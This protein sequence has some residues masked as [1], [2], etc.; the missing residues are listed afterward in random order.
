MVYHSRHHMVHDHVPASTSVATNNTL[1][2]WQ[3]HILVAEDH[4]C[5]Y[6]M[7]LTTNDS[8]HTNSEAEHCA[9]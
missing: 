2:M 3:L 4:F 6:Y 5:L 1:G 8:S 9:E 7:V